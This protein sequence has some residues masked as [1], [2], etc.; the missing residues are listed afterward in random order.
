MKTPFSV[1]IMSFNEEAII[2]KCLKAAA[3]V[4]SDL[5]VIDSGSTDRTLEIAKNYTSQI[6]YN[7]MDTYGA[8]KNIGAQKAKYDWIFALDCDEVLNEELIT[9]LKQAS[10]E[11]GHIYRL[12][13]HTY[14]GDKKLN[15]S[16]LSPDWINRIY[17]RDENKFDDYLVH[18][19][20]TGFD[21][22]KRIKMP[23]YAHH[24][25]YND[26]EDLKTKYLKYA[27]LGAQNRIDYNIKPSVLQVAFGPLFRFCK[28]YFWQL[29]ILDGNLGLQISIESARMVRN[30]YR[31]YFDLQKKR[32]K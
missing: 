24:Y 9:Y 11:R 32:S 13:R 14:I 1:V 18:E 21:S 30:R 26:M 22:M 15:F 23:G 25:S 31:H 7:K 10:F 12:G 17:H 19:R 20:L 4:S 8:Q 27:M 28:T 3:Q 16:G 6:F 2:E 29:G 5:I